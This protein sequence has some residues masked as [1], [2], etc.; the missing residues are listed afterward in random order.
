MHAFCFSLHTPTIYQRSPVFPEGEKGMLFQHKLLRIQ[1]QVNIQLLPWSA[2]LQHM[3]AENCSNWTPP[4]AVHLHDNFGW[5]DSC[6]TDHELISQA[7]TELLSHFTAS[8]STWHDCFASLST[9]EDVAQS[10]LIISVQKKKKKIL[11]RM[12]GHKK[13]MSGSYLDVINER[14]SGESS[15]TGMSNDASFVSSHTSWR[16]ADLSGCGLWMEPEYSHPPL[17]QVPFWNFVPL[18]IS[19]RFQTSE[20]QMQL[21]CCLSSHL[22]ESDR[23]YCR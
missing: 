9:W 7:P 14:E 23:G 2:V 15:I 20:M 3:S 18:A 22:S 17:W 16:L 10:S 1:T 13:V 5:N 21:T 12:C 19:L 8:R 11:L 4:S 6:V